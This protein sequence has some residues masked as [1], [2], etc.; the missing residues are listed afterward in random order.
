MGNVISE[1][2]PI[3][4]EKCDIPDAA[5]QR[6][7]RITYII[8]VIVW[9]VL[10][11]TLKLYDI[12]ILGWIIILIPFI[13]FTISFSSVDE[14]TERVAQHI[15][16]GNF[17]SFA[18]LIVIVIINWDKSSNMAPFLPILAVALILIML[19]LV[20]VWVSNERALYT[21]HLR[22]IF[23]TMALSLLSYTLYSYYLYESSIINRGNTNKNDELACHRLENLSD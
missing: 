16:Q 7:I 21:R 4:D 23:Q 6:E 2:D 17:L 10:I 12:D 18:F 11:F 19:S 9:I 15:N 13:V 5:R 3:I 1:Q 20:D 8:A 14:C 22:T